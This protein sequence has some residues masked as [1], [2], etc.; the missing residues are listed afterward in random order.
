MSSTWSDPARMLG[1]GHASGPFIFVIIAALFEVFKRVMRFGSLLRL[2]RNNEPNQT[3]F[4]F[5]A[6]RS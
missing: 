6:L 2:S 3:L 4:I 5:G 1:I